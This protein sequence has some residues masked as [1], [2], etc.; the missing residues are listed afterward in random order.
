MTTAEE[1]LS[2]DRR[3]RDDRRVLLRYSLLTAALALPLV[4]S[5]FSLRNVY[6]FAASTMMLADRDMQGP[7]DYYEL[8]GETVEG[9]TIDLPPI[10]LTNALTGRNW[11]LVS[12]AVENKAFT[13]PHPHPENIAVTAAFGGVDKLPRAKR[14]DDL[15]RAWGAI[16][17]SR[18]PATSRQKLRAVRLDNYRWEGGIGGEYHRL[19]QSWTIVL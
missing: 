1:R 8:R 12:A 10:R 7:R 19:V 13:I 6:P 17:N 18:L 15:L 4:L 11:S 5:F 16:Y 9:Q 3:S 2:E 14:L